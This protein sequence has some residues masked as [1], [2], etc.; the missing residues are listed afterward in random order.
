MKHAL[1]EGLALKS[2]MEIETSVLPVTGQ[3]QCQKRGFERYR[4]V[5]PI[6]VRD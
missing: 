1:D 5:S 2:S 6:M 4:L 3:E